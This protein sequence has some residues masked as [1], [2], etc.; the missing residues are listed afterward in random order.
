MK[1]DNK[2]LKQSLRDEDFFL[3]ANLETYLLKYKIRFIH[4]KNKAIAPTC[5]LKPARQSQGGI[6]YRMAVI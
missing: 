1:E 2:I 5:C 6:Q 3:R 4:P